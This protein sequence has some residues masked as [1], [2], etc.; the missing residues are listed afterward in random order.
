MGVVVN[1]AT[2]FAFQTEPAYYQ[3]FD[4]YFHV[5]P[6][7]IH[8]R[9]DLVLKSNENNEKIIYKPVNNNYIGVGFFM[10]DANFAIN[11]PTNFSSKNI[12]MRSSVALRRFG[13][14][15]SYQNYNTFETPVDV[16]DARFRELKL[17][18]IYIFNHRKF[19]LPASINQNE[20]QLR[21]AGSPLLIMSVSRTHLSNSEGVVGPGSI[22]SFPQLDGVNQFRQWMWGVM[23]GYSYSWVKEDWIVNGTL[24]VGVSHYWE[25]YHTD[26]DRTSDVNLNLSSKARLYAGIDKLKYFAGI[27]AEWDHLGSSSEITRNRVRFFSVRLAFGLRF[28]EKGLLERSG[29]EIFSF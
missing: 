9:V 6:Q 23:P 28:L 25:F 12:D 22:N 15:A 3:E 17:D 24:G 14:E 21:S 8:R 20:K 29:S 26:T 16:L 7:F 13:I 1:M 5:R 18:G 19:S 2:T 11:F 10:F 27:L 4:K